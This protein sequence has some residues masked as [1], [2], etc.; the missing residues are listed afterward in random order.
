MARWHRPR[1][2]YVFDRDDRAVLHLWCGQGISTP[3]RRS[4]E[5]EPPTTGHLSAAPVRAAQPLPD[6]TLVF[7]PKAAIDVPRVCPGASRSGLYAEQPGGRTGLCLACGQTQRIVGGSC[8][9]YGWRPL[10]LTTHEPGPDLIQPCWW[11]GWAELVARDGHAVCGPCA[12]AG[13]P[14]AGAP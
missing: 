10:R 7:S 3:T 13:W 8:G 9:G 1:S 12:V 5:T 11:H 2:G 14:S 4:D 6:R